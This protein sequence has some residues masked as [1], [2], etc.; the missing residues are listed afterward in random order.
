V[1]LESIGPEIDSQELV[2]IDWPPVVVRDGEL[3]STVIYRDT[4]GNLKLAGL[5]PDLIEALD[6]VEHGDVLEVRLGASDKPLEMP[7]APTFGHVAAGD[8]VVL[9]DSYGRLSIAQ[10]QG[11]AAKSLSVNE[12][13]T[14]T[15]RRA[16]VPPGEPAAETSD[17]DQAAE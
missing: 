8:Y 16:P 9:E 13:T 11:S 2:Q 1:P 6:G 7:W 4:F 17:E 14:V 3:E 15:L 5:T 10:N 12:G